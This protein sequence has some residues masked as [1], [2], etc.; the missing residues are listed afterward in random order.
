MLPGDA[1][2]LYTDGITEAHDPQQQMYGLDRLE[3]V[4]REA[5]ISPVQNLV[6]R[7]IS[8]V[9]EFAGGT[10]QYDDITLMVIRYCRESA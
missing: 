9:D 10:P 3:T 1:L 6:D 2:V 4:C 5:P 7:V 8:S